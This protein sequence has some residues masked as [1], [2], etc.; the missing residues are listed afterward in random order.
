MSSTWCGMICRCET[1]RVSSVSLRPLPAWGFP[2]RI[3]TQKTWGKAHRNEDG[4]FRAQRENSEGELVLGAVDLLD[5]AR[6][7]LLCEKLEQVA[8][9]L[10]VTNW[11]W[12][13]PEQP[14]AALALFLSGCG[15]TLLGCWW[16]EDS[17]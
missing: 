8:D 2:L 11:S 15:G 12:P 6:P 9:H 17:P 1:L 7:L 16:P 10:G 4:D 14:E 13:T 3:R 5:A